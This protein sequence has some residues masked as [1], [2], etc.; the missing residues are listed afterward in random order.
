MYDE[1][2]TSRI[3]RLAAVLGTGSLLALAAAGPLH[4]LG[5]VGLTGAFGILKFGAFGALATLPLA[6]GGLVVAARRRASAS[7]AT[8]A[9]FLSLAAIA[10]IGALA[11]KASRV[12]VISKLVT[13]VLMSVAL[14]VN[15]PFIT[16]GANAI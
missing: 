1:P 11:W 2:K 9:L 3:A 4:H 15:A 6:I 16:I 12:P 5:L 7:A 8:Y 14:I 13:C 10:S